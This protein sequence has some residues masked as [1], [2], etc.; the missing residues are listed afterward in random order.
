[1]CDQ[2]CKFGTDREYMMISDLSPQK[3]LPTFLLEFIVGCRDRVKCVGH[4]LRVVFVSGPI[5]PADL[6]I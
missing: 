2:M 1:M 4:N 6:L 3:S 5:V